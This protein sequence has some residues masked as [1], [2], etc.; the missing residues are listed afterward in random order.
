M[1]AET[2]TSWKGIK[3]GT[4]FKVVS[5]S[6]SHNY[7]LNTVL[8]LSR[9][10]LVSSEMGNAAVE[11]S[12][13]NLN[14]QDVVILT[15]TTVADLQK[16]LSAAK[17]VVKEIQQKITFCGENELE[18]FDEETYRIFKL[19]EIAEGTGTRMQKAYAL[20]QALQG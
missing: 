10:G 16:E 19:L 5:N 6:N 4:K 17:A 20:A 9:D 3:K 1:A 8:T 18:E 7:P 13:N 11:L 2:L 12:G 14:I 15:A